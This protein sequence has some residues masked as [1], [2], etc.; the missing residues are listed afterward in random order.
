VG[1]GLWG[2][3]FDIPRSKRRNTIISWFLRSSVEEGKKSLMSSGQKEL[4]ELR[5]IRAQQKAEAEAEA[6]LQ[7]E[8]DAAKAKKAAFLSKA[9]A[10]QAKPTRRDSVI[11]AE[12]QK[13]SQKRKMGNNLNKILGAQLAGVKAP[14]SLQKAAPPPPPPPPGT[15][16]APVAQ[17]PPPPK[18]IEPPR[19]MWMAHA[20]A[21][22]ATTAASVSKVAVPEVVLPEPTQEEIDAA[23][24]YVYLN[25]PNPYYW[26]TV[27]GKTT[28]DINETS[29]AGQ[30]GIRM[31]AIEEAMTSAKWVYVHENEPTPYFWNTHSGETTYDVAET[32]LDPALYTVGE[33]GEK[34]AAAA[35]CEWWQESFIS[36]GIWQYTNLTTGA[37]IDY[38][39]D[40]SVVVV[41]ED[42]TTGE[43][44]NWQEYSHNGETVTLENGLVLATGSVYYQN[45]ATNEVLLERPWGN[46]MIIVESKA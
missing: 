13:E 22:P 2:R 40:G 24:Q 26:N 18:P 7:A 36:E 28:F 10:F 17:P 32:D 23:W 35:V 33:A 1:H 39:P 38:R 21:P 12:I 8:K 31:A 25:E 5:R 20:K 9:S 37:T 30:K 3:G 6:A 42:E 43:T 27:T 45:S 29:L 11:K 15:K 14:P 46:V 44:I 19:S 16:V 34:A 41:A 4:E